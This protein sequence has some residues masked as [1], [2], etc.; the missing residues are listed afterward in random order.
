MS[1]YLQSRVERIDRRH[2]EVSFCL[3]ACLRVYYSS[4]MAVI[5]VVFARS[6]RGV[7]KICV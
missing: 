1:G 3:S 2:G 4:C 7:K 6:S 5:A